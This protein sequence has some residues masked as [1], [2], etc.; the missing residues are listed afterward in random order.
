MA[1]D[2]QGHV[3]DRVRDPRR[4]CC[5]RPASACSAACCSACP[6]R[7]SP[8]R[9]ARF[10]ASGLLASTSL[11]ANRWRT[12]A[13]ATPIVLVAML[14]GTQGVVQSSGQRDAERVTAARVDR[15]VRRHRPRR[16]ADPGRTR[17]AA[18]TRASRATSIYPDGRARRGRAVAGRRRAH[19]RRAGA[20]PRLHAGGLDVSAATASPS[21]AC[22]PRRGD[23]RVGDTFGARLADTSPP[24]PAR[25]GD[26]RA[27][28]RPRRRARRRR[29]RRRS[30]AIFVAAATAPDV[31]GVAGPDPR[32]VPRRAARRRATSRPGRSG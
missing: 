5:W 27:R 23:L 30:T 16:R 24:H 4:A 11:A 28:R 6:R 26:L 17:I 20:R 12:A 18:A 31:A 15:A 8:A 21:A 3:G 7:C 13:L 2:L 9:C 10:G 19:A 32:R 25:R 22:S 1:L 29:A 14:A